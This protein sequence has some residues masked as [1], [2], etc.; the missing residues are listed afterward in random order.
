MIVDIIRNTPFGVWILFV[1]LIKRGVGA[2]QQ[3]KVSLAKLL[4]IPSLFLIWG[5]HDS[6]T[7]I[8]IETLTILL[9][10][11]SFIVGFVLL[12]SINHFYGKMSLM[13]QIPEY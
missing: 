9:F 5:V 4:V 3:R 6:I 11:L 12:L 10:F 8:P 1:F 13:I 2:L 7:K